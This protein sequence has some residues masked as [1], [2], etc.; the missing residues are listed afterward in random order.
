MKKYLIVLAVALV[1]LASCNN[2][3]AV[4]GISLNPSKIEKFY[5]GDTVRLGLTVT[6]AE[7]QLKENVK[8]MSS[9]TD[10]VKVV[11][12]NGRITAV[13]PGE[14]V[15]TAVAGEFQAACQIYANYEV[16]FWNVAQMFY[17]PSTKSKEPLNDS[18]YD[19]DGV[20]CQLYSV[21]FLCPNGNDYS[22]D[23]DS[24]EGLSLF[25]DVS[26]F[27][28][29][30]G[31][32][33][34]KASLAGTRREFTIVDDEEVW[35][36]TPYTALS[37]ELYPEIAGPIYQDFL[38]KYAAGDA[39][40]KPD[41]ATFQEQATRGA[42]VGN[43]EMSDEGVSYSY[44]PDGLVKV[45]NCKRVNGQVKYDLTVQWIVSGWWGLAVNPDAT[46]YADLLLY[47]YELTTSALCEYKD[48][49]LL[50]EFLEDEEEGG[51]EANAPRHSAARKSAKAM[52]INL[53]KPVPVYYDA[54]KQIAK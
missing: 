39:S 25:A 13:H 11:N 51:D 14:A 30:E 42:H 46:S 45:G 20:K 10:V 17:F 41:W 23:F 40:A 48:G 49:E 50:G 15:V 7:A 24:G 27:F 8:W 18:I 29:I 52:K 36:N 54:H 1:A 6:P 43:A 34:E 19:V 2:E 21:T 44:I 38:E 33:D 9:D 28:P 5:I 26:A 3:T 47:P 31:T 32:E 4:T 53:G 37:G 16:L 22:E 35:K 12:Q